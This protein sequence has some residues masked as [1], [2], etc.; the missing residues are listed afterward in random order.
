MRRYA[1][2]R[3]LDRFLI[4]LLLFR[5]KFLRILAMHLKFKRPF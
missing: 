5:S 2:V 1:A 4:Q 3:L